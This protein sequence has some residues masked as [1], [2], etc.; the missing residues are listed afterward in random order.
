[1][2]T[3]RLSGK[4]IEIGGIIYKIKYRGRKNA[5]SK[6]KELAARGEIDFDKRTIELE[7][8]LSPSEEIVVI[9]YELLHAS[10]DSFIPARMLDEFEELEELIVDPLSRILVGALRSAGLLRE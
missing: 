2:K 9:I 4:T 1:M 8:G 5:S 7:K 3:N 6:S 10:L